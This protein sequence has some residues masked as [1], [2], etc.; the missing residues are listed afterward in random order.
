MSGSLT[1]HLKTSAVWPQLIFANLSNSFVLFTHMSINKNYTFPHLG[2]VYA[3]SL[4]KSIS[5]SGHL[6]FRCSQAPFTPSFAYRIPLSYAVPIPCDSD[7][8][9]FIDPHLWAMSP[10][11][12]R[13]SSHN[14]G[15][16]NG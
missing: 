1:W 16:R 5:Y 8:L 14:D 12:D 3:V 7:G 4:P 6:G 15:F 2:F 9:T 13:L 11:N 10:K